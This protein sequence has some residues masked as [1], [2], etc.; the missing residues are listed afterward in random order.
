MAPLAG[1]TWTE[2]AGLLTAAEAG[3]GAAGASR[4]CPR[5]L[6]I[7]GRPTRGTSWARKAN[8]PVESRCEGTAWPSAAAT[9]SPAALNS[10][11]STTRSVRGQDDVLNTSTALAIGSPPRPASAEAS[12]FRDW[13]SASSANACLIFHWSLTNGLSGSSMLL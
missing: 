11:P 10:L 13:A 9:T 3:L 5:R 12:S 2:I 7:A 1:S 6:C 4:P 8:S